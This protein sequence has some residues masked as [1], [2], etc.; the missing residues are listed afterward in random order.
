VL[1]T[2]A[3]GEEWRGM[4]V[5]SEAPSS[6]VRGPFPCYHGKPLGLKVYWERNELSDAELFMSCSSILFALI[7]DSHDPGLGAGRLGPHT[8]GL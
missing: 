4:L 6:Q 7:C 8:G 1:G 5:D 3:A 2:R